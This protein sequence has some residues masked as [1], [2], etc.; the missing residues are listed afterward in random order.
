M[1]G[2]DVFT[3]T[4]DLLILKALTWG[5]RHGY[6]I[7][8]WIRETTEEVLVIQEGALYPALHRLE[9]KT[10]VSEEWGATDSGRQA[11]YYTLTAKGRAQLR[12]ESVRFASYAHA[13]GRA[14]ATT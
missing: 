3:G 1:P 11:K 14:L 6:A 7:G 10:F 12:R 9:R 5:P 13:V 4:L 2:S 8:R